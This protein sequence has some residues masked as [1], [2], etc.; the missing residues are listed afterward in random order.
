MNPS[1]KAGRLAT[2]T[3]IALL[4]LAL[5]AGCALS[6]APAPAGAWSAGSGTT[7]VRVHYDT[8]FGNRIAIRGSAAPLSW[9]AGRDAAWTSG[10][11]WVASWSSSAGDLDLKP[12]IND[13]A[14]SIG[15]NYHVRA[16][17]TVDIY[18]YFH[19]STGR[20][21]PVPNFG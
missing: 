11:V 14:W 4:A 20:L 19:A 16:G 17:A 15:A 18:P 12:L 1:T 21:M 13:A 10:N 2:V 3:T 8:G 5:G 9:S 6:E 7:T